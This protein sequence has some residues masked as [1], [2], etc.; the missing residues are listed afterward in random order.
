MPDPKK[1]RSI[2]KSIGFD[3]GSQ[4]KAVD[5]SR[6]FAL[7]SKIVSKT[8]RNLRSEIYGAD[9]GDA[10]VVLLLSEGDSDDGAIVFLTT[11]FRDA[12]EGDAVKAVSHVTKKQPFTGASVRNADGK[13][14]RRVFWD[15][16]GVAGVRGM[17][18]SG[19]E[20]ADALH[21]PRGI[22]AFNKAAATP[23]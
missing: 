17:V 9:R 15:V 23:S 1:I 8:V 21:L 19:P 22:T 4:Q 2:F 10:P 13:L 14:V 20:N 7:E 16:E 18:V 12:I 3:I 11:I 5:A 6:M